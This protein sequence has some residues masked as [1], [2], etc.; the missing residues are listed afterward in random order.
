MPTS[1]SPLPVTHEPPPNRIRWTRRQ[2][3]AIRDADVLTGRYEL[4]DGEIV[5][6][7][8]Q[9]PP[10]RIGVVLVREWLSRVF[11][12]LHVQVQATIDVAA[13]DP[14]HN[15]P[16]PDAAVTAQ[17]ATAYVQQHPGPEDLL[18]IVEVADSS[19]T[20]DRG[21]KA[22]LYARAGIGEYWVVDLVGR[23][24]YVHRGPGVDG[25]LE[26]TWYASDER[27]A[28]LVRPGASTLVADLLP[29]TV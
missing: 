20:Y 1:V 7:V 17:P 2:C 25:Y 18:L 16:E 14:D 21:L 8:G 9:S 24:L 27:V 13:A 19:L 11:G 5:S 3:E 28:P 22:L 10:H 6:K 12:G 26:I 15:E 29:P 4:I 23:A